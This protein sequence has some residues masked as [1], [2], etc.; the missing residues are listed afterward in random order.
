MNQKP[1]VLGIF[2]HPDDE[3][4]AGWPIFQSNEYE[5]Y[6]M[7]CCS[8]KE[9]NRPNRKRALQEVLLAMTKPEFKKVTKNLVITVLHAGPFGQVI[10]MKPIKGKYRIMQMTVPRDMPITALK[11]VVAHELG[12]V[13]HGRNWIPS[14]GDR[15]E[16][17]AD[18]WAEK[19]GFPK[20][21][22]F[23]K[24]ARKHHKRLL[25]MRRYK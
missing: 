21:F 8:D 18:R 17:H 14:D 10:H 5:K 4:L 20:S 12:H 7:I 15:L 25:Y 2:C 19:W 6:L 9:R 1:K 22:T 23:E 11:Y 16:K 24:Y 3:I 13:M